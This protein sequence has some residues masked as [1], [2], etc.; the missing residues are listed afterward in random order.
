VRLAIGAGRARL[1]RQL[2]TESLVIALAGAALGL[3]MAQFVV[4]AFSNAQIP[5][6]IPI[7]L[8]FELDQ[9]LLWFTIFVAGACAILFGLA[10]ALRATR[11]DLVPALKAGDSIQNR[12]HWF[13]RNALVTLQIAGSLVL[14]VAATQLFRGFS[15]L[16]SHGP[17]FRTDHLIMMSFDPTLV[18]YT[19]QQ[20]EQLDKKLIDRA[21]ALPGVKSAALS[22][23]IPLGTNQQEYEEVIPEGFQ[24]RFAP[25]AGGVGPK[26]PR[27]YS[28]PAGA[29]DGGI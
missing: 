22:F 28:F 25:R 12:N 29:N 10:P 20:I 23:S 26:A 5:S 16:V 17:G 15:Y 13:G 2:M 21:E 7:Q 6:D 19:P 1:V 14:L 3:L 18:R 4:E 9:R 11:T 8:S 24:F 27:R